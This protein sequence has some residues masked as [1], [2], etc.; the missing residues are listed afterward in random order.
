MPKK[1]VSP[2]RNIVGVIILVG[3]IVFGVFEYTA[4]SGYNSAVSALN[5]RMEDDEK[6]LLTVKEAETLM[7]KEADGP[8]V[9]FKQDVWNF[10]QKTYT[11]RG[12]VKQYSLTAYYTKEKDS[13]LHHIETEGQKYQ[14]AAPKQDGPPSRKRQ[15]AKGSGGQPERG[16]QAA[17]RPGTAKPDSDSKEKTPEPAAKA[18][19]TAKPE[20]AVDP[21]TKP[22]APE[23]SDKGDAPK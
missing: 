19:S 22:K 11:W 15:S 7:G 16:A 5:T 4:K 3:V 18:P 12:L 2:V 14:L 20:P 6:G 10:D 8:A 13:R 9:E 23:P 21:A 1:A 17:L